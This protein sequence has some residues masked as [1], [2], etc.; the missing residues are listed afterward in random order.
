MSFS[1][2]RVQ[3]SRQEMIADLQDMSK[4]RLNDCLSGY[5]ASTVSLQAVIT[6]SMRYR[7]YIEGQKF[8]ATAP[9]RIIFYRGL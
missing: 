5:Q 9:K 7:Q 1:E 8:P 6:L 3:A 4:V 2:S